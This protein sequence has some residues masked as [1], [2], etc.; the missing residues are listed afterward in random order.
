MDGYPSLSAVSTAGNSRRVKRPTCPCRGLLVRLAG[1]AA[2]GKDGGNNRCSAC[3]VLHNAWH[4]TRSR[5]RH[6]GGTGNPCRARLP[7]LCL[8]AIMTNS[9]NLIKV[10][11]GYLLLFKL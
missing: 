4:L 2:I 6:Q 1:P 7:R 8:P 5:W 9:C 11:F 3:L 10:V